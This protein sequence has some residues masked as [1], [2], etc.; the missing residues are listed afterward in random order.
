MTSVPTPDVPAPDLDA[1]RQFLA[2]GGRIVD[3]RRVRPPVR[4]RAARAGA[5]RGGRLPQPRRRLRPRAR[6]R[7]PAVRAASPPRCAQALRTLDEAD[8]WDAAAWPRGACDWLAAHPADGGAPGGAAAA[9]CS[10]S[11]PL[12]GWPHAPWWVPAAGEGRLASLISTG[13]CWP[14]C[15]TPGGCEHPWLDRATTADVVDRIDGLVEP[16]AVRH[17]AACSAFL[18]HVPDRGPRPGGGSSGPR[19]AAIGQAGR[20]RPERR[21]ARPTHRSFFAPLPTSAGPGGCSALRLRSS[22]H[23]DHL[24]RAQGDGRRLDVQLAGLVPGGGARAGAGS[25]PSEALFTLRA[26]GRL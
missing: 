6:A 25:S 24:V 3:R 9:A 12:A 16:S 20:T 14:G 22:V 4:R 26:N 8:A 2:V 10:S 21:R 19:A 5:R 17:A 15:C 1:A 13:R 18:Q 23:L 11:R 7:L